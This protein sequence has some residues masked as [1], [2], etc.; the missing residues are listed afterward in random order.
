MK[1]IS[2]EKQKK[3]F[4]ILS[5]SF[6]LNVN[7][8]TVTTLAGGIQGN[9][10]G[11]GTAAQFAFP[12]GLALDANG[13]IYVADRLND[14]IR[15]ITAS[16]EVNT[17]AGSFAGYVDA[18][19]TVAQFHAPTG[20]AVDAAGT[21]FVAD[22]QNNRIRKITA[23]GVVS[24]FAGST[25]GFADG[26]GDS[27]KFYDPSGVAVD[28]SGNVFVA[29]TANN[30]IRKITVGGVVSTIAGSI[31]GFADGNGTAAKFYSPT[32]VA[33]NAEGDIFV[34]DLINNRIRKIT[35]TGV[36]STLA[37]STPGFAD[38][39]GTVALFDN[40]YSV[41]IDALGNI[42]VADTSNNRIRRITAAGEVSTLAGSTAGFADGTGITAQFN[43]P[44]GVAI[45]IAGNIFVA[46]ENN[47]RIRK[48]TSDLGTAN[49]KLENHVLFYPNPA[50]TIIHIELDD[51]SAA[52]ITI[53]D[54]NGRALQSDNI[55][56]KSQ[57]INI[58]DLSNGIYLLQ[59]ITDSGTVSKKM[60]K[61]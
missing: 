54:M 11:I 45:D 53:F 29:D 49:Y 48:I 14:R 46:D 34:A 4:F 31:A 42:I 5:L 37:G 24:T 22:S 30:L 39:I 23:A 55:I 33:V 2:Q 17:L 40:P 41:A 52:K 20:V 21:I 19:G 59:I 12:S 9:A 3:I 57:A 61:Q 16:G 26:A 13:Y 44:Y 15:K 51:I 38:G 27:A 56:N 43:H 6:F 8:Q 60:L 36:V 28:A 35:A 50:T 25:A 7:A 47:N 1:S 58:G 32:G 10:E 18:A